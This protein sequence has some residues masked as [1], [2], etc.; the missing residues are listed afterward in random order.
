MRYRIEQA[1]RLLGKQRLSISEVALQM[2]FN[3]AQ[4]F[5]RVF[6]RVMEISPS[7]YVNGATTDVSKEQIYVDYS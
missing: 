2:D 5:S 6:K 1:K 4:H 7:R 3:K